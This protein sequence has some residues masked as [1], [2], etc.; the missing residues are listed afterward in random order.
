MPFCSGT[1]LGSTAA[2]A[3]A[4]STQILFD[5]RLRLVNAALA[6]LRSFAMMIA[7]VG[8][9]C[10]PDKSSDSAVCSA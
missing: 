6:M 10:L 8:C 1:H 9:S 7:S 2:I 5:L 3:F 4:P